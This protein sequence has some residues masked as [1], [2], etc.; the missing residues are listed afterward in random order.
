VA[1]KLRIFNEETAPLLDHYRA[2]GVGIE[3]VTVGVG[4][5]AAALCAQL[6]S[7][8]RRRCPNH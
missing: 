8:P 1:N 7:R 2:M 6:A 5:T 4:T 3:K